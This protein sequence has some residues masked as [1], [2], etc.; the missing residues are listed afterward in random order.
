[1]TETN[2]GTRL[3]FDSS[4]LNYFARANLLD[5]LEKLV[6][7]HTCLLTSAVAQELQRGASR[8]TRL[9]MVG[10]QPWLREV[11]D[12]S[13]A[14][15]ASFSAFH[16]RLGG[17]T[18]DMKDLGEATTLAYA[19]L[20]GCTAIIDDRAGRNIGIAHGV[21][22]STTLQLICHGIRNGLV[23]DDQAC[24]VVDALRDV[25]AFLPCSGSD[26]IDWAR[27]AGLLD[28]A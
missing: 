19:D 27:A 7:G 28:P 8:Y 10:A 20:H 6:A 15:L 26:F 9:H 1:V 18:G 25:E 22:I 2:M 17:G 24:A 11:S 5:V 12:D 4:P 13:L 14:Y 23:T 21:S 16:A 3:V